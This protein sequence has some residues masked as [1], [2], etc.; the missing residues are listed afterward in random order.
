MLF[1]ALKFNIWE[2]EG[3]PLVLVSLGW[4]YALRCVAMFLIFRKMGETPWKAFIPFYSLYVLV[5]CVWN[6]NIFWQMMFFMLIA[7]VCAVLNAFGVFSEPISFYFTLGYYLVSLLMIFV[8]RTLIFLQLCKSFKEHISVW[9]VMFFFPVLM[10][11]KIGL[12]EKN[13]YKGP[14]RFYKK[15][16]LNISPDGT[17]FEL[18]LEQINDSEGEVGVKFK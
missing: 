14:A 12:E 13:F 15:R 9:V 8:I 5:K 4:L 10:F 2:W 1:S 18:D 11:L 6:Q 7:V 3:L 17:L 16:P